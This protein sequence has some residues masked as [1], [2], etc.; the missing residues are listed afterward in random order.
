MRCLRLGGVLQSSA[1]PTTQAVDPIENAGGP[2]TPR[3]CESPAVAAKHR[4]RVS[5]GYE[6]ASELALLVAF[7]EPDAA[8]SRMA[9]YRVDSVIISFE[10]IALVMIAVRKRG[11]KPNF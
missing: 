9:E 7:D 2:S 5:E 11:Q 4:G 8:G 1:S 10:A 6:H 3:A